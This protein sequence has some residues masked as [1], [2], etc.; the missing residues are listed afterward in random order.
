LQDYVIHRD[1][2]CSKLVFIM[3]E[4]L[5]MNLKQL[6]ATAAAWP[7]GPLPPLGPPQQAQQERGAQAGAGGSTREGLPPAS[8]FA[9]TNVKQLQILCGVL[10]PLL[11]PEE[12]H[13][14]FSRVALMFSTTLVEAFGLLEPRGPAWEQQLQVCGSQKYPMRCANGG[15]CSRWRTCCNSSRCSHVQHAGALDQSAAVACA[16]HCCAPAQQLWPL[17]VL[18]GGCAGEGGCVVMLVLLLSACRLMCWRCW[19]AWSSCLWR[20]GREMPA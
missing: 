10:A 16:V 4:R 19:S 7:S 5:S 11:L 9:A 20:Q 8:A 6:P 12:A 15:S 17:V 18:E 1:E 2:I 3:R 14:I 13:S